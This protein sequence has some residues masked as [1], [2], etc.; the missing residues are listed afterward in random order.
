MKNIFFA[1]LSC[2]CFASCGTPMSDVMTMCDKKTSFD[3]YVYCVKSV[4]S[5]EGRQPDSLS[6]RAFYAYL[7]SI[8]ESYLA[9]KISNAQARAYAYEA[10]QRTVQAANDRAEAAA[11]NAFIMQQSAEQQN[12]PIQTNCVKTGDFINCSSR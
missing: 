3:Q 6:I 4:Y 8:N 9:N 1:L 5:T 11:A 10:F 7:D 12:R 2:L